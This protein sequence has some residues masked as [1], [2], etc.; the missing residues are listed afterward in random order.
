MNVS[1]R[2]VLFLLALL[3]GP[4]GGRSGAQEA[5]AADSKIDDLS[6]WDLFE[7]AGG[8]LGWRPDWPRA[9][10]PDLFDVPG[11]LSVAVNFGD[12]TSLEL[13]RE[14]RRLTAF[15]VLVSSAEGSV[16]TQGRA[17]YD[18]L[19][20]C[21]KVS[22]NGGGEGQSFDVE[23]LEWDDENRPLLT[24]VFAG[25]YYFAA[26][27][28]PG[29]ETWY[30]RDGVVLF[31]LMHGAASRRQIT[32]RFP[33]REE[34]A[35][36]GEEI[37]ETRFFHTAGGRISR[38]EGPG[39]TVSVRYDRKGLP[40]YV[41]QTGPPGPAGS[42]PPGPDGSGLEVPVP[43]RPETWSLV[44]QWDEAGRLVRLR[45][46]SSGPAGSEPEIMDCLYEYILDS[47]GNWIER[48]EWSMVSIGPG[49]AQRLAPRS[50]TTTRRTIR[51][52]EA[53]GGISP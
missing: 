19:G 31:V 2:A 10:A 7:A 3:L 53:G 48:R 34:E 6:L 35:A 1:V 49:E 45:G 30:G 21:S 24:R 32:P 33:S 4:G 52:E 23:V 43:A 41:E 25:D 16:F 13:V 38:I 11:A 46:G 50:S 12:G 28:Y 15:P 20:R 27:E 18:S 8:R 44:Y 39:G 17:E 22:W 5:G 37:R 36:A 47:R 40:R 14:D 9:A 42:D 26:L 29:F 51:Y